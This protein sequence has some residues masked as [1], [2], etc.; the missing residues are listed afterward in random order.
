M[1]HKWLKRLISVLEIGGGF[2]GLIICLSALFNPSDT[3]A[4]TALLLLFSVVF[5]F[6]IIAGVCLIE[7]RKYGTILSLLYQAIQVFELSSGLITYSLGSGIVFNLVILNR[8]FSFEFTFGSHFSLYFFQADAPFG[9]G[10]NLVALFFFLYLLGVWIN[11]SKQKTEQQGT[12]EQQE[13]D[14][15]EDDK[16]PFIF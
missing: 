9:L 4:N 1:I 16:Q 5:F 11:E 12:D 10:I 8:Q 6:G 2:L 15:A 7:N 3:F 13:A 14:L